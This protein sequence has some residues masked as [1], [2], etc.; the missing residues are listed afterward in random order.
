[1]I[2]T[3]SRMPSLLKSA[4]TMEWL[5]VSPDGMEPGVNVIWAEAKE[6]K[7]EMANNKVKRRAKR[8]METSNKLIKIERCWR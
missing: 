8:N 7:K 1:L 2:V 5:P 4:E 6:L 3:R